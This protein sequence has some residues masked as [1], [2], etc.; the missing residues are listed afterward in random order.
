MF[1]VQCGQSIPSGTAFC[2]HCGGRQS[3]PGEP[4]KLASAA[5]PVGGSVFVQVGVAAALLLG[6]GI[7]ALLFKGN[8]SQGNSPTPTPSPA[9]VGLSLQDLAGSWRAESFLGEVDSDKRLELKTDGQW[10]RGNLAELIDLNLTSLQDGSARGSFT[11][12][13]IQGQCALSLRDK[14]LRLELTYS[15]GEQHILWFKP[16]VV[17]PVDELTACKSNC[18]NLATA[19]EMYSTDNG[20]RYP[21][22]YEL[23]SKLTTGNYLSKIPTC[24][25]AGT[26]TYSDNYVSTQSPDIFSFYCAGNNHGK[27]YEAYRRNSSNYPMYH[28]NQGLIDHP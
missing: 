25:A 20:G 14:R 28:S 16:Y 3:A 2:S 27:A 10:L 12:Q 13:A 15:S 5:K 8:L 1:C 11:S 22:T 7:G 24:P 18:K 6:A 21:L 19:L 23:N 26:N 17:E 9:T 4:V